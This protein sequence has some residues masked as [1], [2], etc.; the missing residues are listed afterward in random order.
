MV[1]VIE[2]RRRD[3][4]YLFLSSE[5]KVPGLNVTSYSTVQY[6]PESLQDHCELLYKSK[7]RK[8]YLSLRQLLIA[9]NV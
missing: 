7:G 2:W 8:G 5:A 1:S 9:Q 4:N 3:K 6:D